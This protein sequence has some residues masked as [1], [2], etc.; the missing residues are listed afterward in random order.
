MRYRVLCILL[1]S[2]F[3]LGYSNKAD[4]VPSLTKLSAA[5]TQ[6]QSIRDEIKIINSKA[7]VKQG[8]F[9]FI[10]IQGLPNTKYRIT[11]SFKRGNRIVSVNQ[12]RATG[13]NGQATFNWLVD[14]ETAPGTYPAVISGGGKR[15]TTYHTVNP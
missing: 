6:S 14:S 5:Q 1:F 11:T 12:W 8:D 4:L 2:L 9:G 10:T 3:V 7:I 13:V 15:L